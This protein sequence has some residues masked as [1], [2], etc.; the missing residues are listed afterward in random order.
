MIF[1]LFFRMDTSII[2]NT[3]S[4]ERTTAFHGLHETPADRKSHVNPTLR[5]QALSQVPT[6]GYSSVSTRPWCDFFPGDTRPRFLP[7]S[8]LL[9]MQTS[10]QVKSTYARLVPFRNSLGYGQCKNS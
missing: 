6:Q 7:T 3:E 10:W 2:L 8:V 9:R 1:F 5:L 4:G